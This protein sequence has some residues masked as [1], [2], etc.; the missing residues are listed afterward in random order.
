MK[1]RVRLVTRVPRAARVQR[2]RRHGAVGGQVLGER[3]AAAAQRPDRLQSR[4]DRLHLGAQRLDV[5][6]H[7]SIHA[8]AGSSQTRSSSA[9]RREDVARPRSERPEQAELVARELER[10][11]VVAHLHPAFVDD[12]RPARDRRRRARRRGALRRTRRAAPAQDAAHARDQL[13]R[14]ERLGDVVVGAELEADDAVDLVAA[15]SEEDDRH[16]AVRL[17]QA[18]EDLEPARIGQADVEDHQRRRPPRARARARPRR[19][20]TSAARSLRCAA[21]TAACRRCPARPRRSGSRV[22]FDRQEAFDRQVAL[23]RVVVEAEHRRARRRSRAASARSP[24]ASRPTRCRPAGPLRAPS[25]APSRVPPRPR[26]GSRRRARRR[27][28]S[29]G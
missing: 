25:V 5:R 4:R 22:S 2:S 9:S 28:G 6:I 14:R 15:R 10:A 7:G 1:M 12:D 11:A 13:A 23:A 24:R 27:G 19:S 3:V 18:P 8:V 21:R 17:A 20:R 29:S 16:V 26:P